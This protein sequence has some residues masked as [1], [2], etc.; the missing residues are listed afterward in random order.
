MI[1]QKCETWV[2]LFSAIPMRSHILDVQ[3]WTQTKQASALE[4]CPTWMSSTLPFPLRLSPFSSIC[5]LSASTQ[6]WLC[7]VKTGPLLADR[8]HVSRTIF[9]AAQ[10]TP[11]E[12]GEPLKAHPSGFLLIQRGPVWVWGIRLSTAANGNAAARQSFLLLLLRDGK[13]FAQPSLPRTNSTDATSAGASTTRSLLAVCSPNARTLS[14]LGREFLPKAVWK[15]VSRHKKN[16]DSLSPQFYLWTK[17]AMAIIPLHLS[18]TGCFNMYIRIKW[19]LLLLL[20]LL[21]GYGPY[22]Q[23]NETTLMHR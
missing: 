7:A 15:P 3:P 5:L 16:I 23:N 4:F 12:P 19:L 22:V 8:R 11:G 1:I 10:R 17:E 21:K 2:S 18:I 13:S 14:K 6:P 9:Q 20:L